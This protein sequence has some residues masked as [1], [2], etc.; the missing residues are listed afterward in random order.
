MKKEAETINI[1]ECIDDAQANER[2]YPY[3][4]SFV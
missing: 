2:P 4:R 1:A 3:D